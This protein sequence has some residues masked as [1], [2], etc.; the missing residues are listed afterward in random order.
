[1]TRI[2]ARVAPARPIVAMSSAERREPTRVTGGLARAAGLS[3]RV[4]ISQRFRHGRRGS[5]SPQDCTTAGGF[6]LLETLT[7]LAV[8]AVIVVATTGLLHDVLLH[9][10]RGTRRV[11]EAEHLLQAV[12]RLAGDFASARFIRRPNLPGASAPQGLGAMFVG[13]PSSVTF[14]A[15]GGVMVGP[16]GEELIKLTV[17]ADGEVSRLVRRRAAWRE[18][19]A[20]FEDVPPQDPVVMLEGRVD[21]SFTYGRLTSDGALTWSDDWTGEFGLPRLVRVIVREPNSGVDLLAEAPFLVRADAPAACA[22]AA[23]PAN[24]GAGSAANANARRSPQP[25]AGAQPGG[26]ACL[27]NGPSSGPQRPPDQGRTG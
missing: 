18:P 7:A 13:D 16:Q 5:R 22:R 6:T 21:I 20:H 10:D 11:T 15:A 19:H 14:V 2:A 4:R 17:E 26:I 12:H 9:F 23:Q 3:T 27:T 8:T 1:L 24:N 25:A